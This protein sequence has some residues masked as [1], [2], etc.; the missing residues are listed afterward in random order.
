[1]KF[2]CNLKLLT[3]SVINVSLAV[4][5]KSTI[6]SLEG[7]L[8]KCNNNKLELIGYNLEFG[9]IKTIDVISEKNGQIVLNA[10]IL[11]EIIKRMPEEEIYIEVDNRNIV[12]IKSGNSEFTLNG[13]SAEDF[14]DIPEIN[15][16]NNFSIQSSILKNMINQTIFAISTNEQNP[17]YT[18]SLFDI[19][20]NNITIVSVDGYRLAI[21]KEPINV[22][23]NFSFIVPGNTLK[24]ILK[25]IKDDKSNEIESIIN[26]NFSNKHIIFKIDDYII[27]SRLLEGQFIDYKS[28]IKSNNIT[29][30]DINTKLFIKSIERVSV[31]I[32][33]RL[34]SPVKCI[35]ENNTIN[36]SCSTNLGK[37]TDSFEI[38]KKGEDI[39]IGFNNRYMIEALKSCETDKVII[40]L[41]SSDS[42]I[43]ILPIDNGKEFLF[44]VLP[45]RL[46]ND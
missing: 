25:L 33:D 35:I 10:K 42:P 17:I 44:L 9:I 28:I 19:N 40:E 26:I 16:T 34:K 12:F 22:N 43:K 20:E 2:K 11:T 38:Q 18:G 27:I 23:D 4:S 45:V 8:M 3:E 5:S 37:V 39:T 6:M 1:M 36:L 21:R 41:E 46:K 14:P 7:I 30:F 31:I 32:N 15:N 24:E 13:I 29:E